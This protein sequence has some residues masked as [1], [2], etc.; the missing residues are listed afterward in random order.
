MSRD[1]LKLTAREEG[2]GSY[3]A[4]IGI[5]LGTARVSE[6]HVGVGLAD[7][8]LALLNGH[9]TPCVRACDVVSVVDE[10]LEE[11]EHERRA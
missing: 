6:V 8:I 9:P 7:R 1:G 3:L 11:N 4:T 2:R 10:L 5:Y